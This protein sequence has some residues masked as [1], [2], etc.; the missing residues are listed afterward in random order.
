M[1]ADKHGDL[2]FTQLAA[3]ISEHEGWDEHGG[4][5]SRSKTTSEAPSRDGTGAF[6]SRNVVILT[7]RYAILFL[8]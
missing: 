3:Q 7:S 5:F 2:Q 6:P 1:T 8:H 4:G